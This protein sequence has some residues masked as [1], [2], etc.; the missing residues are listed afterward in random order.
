MIS[1]HWKALLAAFFLFVAGVAVGVVGTI[2]IGLR[3]MRAMLREPATQG[4]IEKALG[5][6]ENRLTRELDLDAA[7]TAMV[8][9]EFE[10]TGDE[11]RAM[12]VDTVQRSRRAIGAAVLRIGAELPPEK[13]A[14]LRRL[15]A[16]RL[17]R[18]G[19]DL[20]PE[21]QPATTSPRPPAAP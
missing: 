21:E 1:I 17:E 5:R 2:G 10:R 4:R 7:Q 11:M 15:V 13:R 12:R 20:P 14:E 9:R 19:L 8:H 18:L 3:H 16:R 6:I